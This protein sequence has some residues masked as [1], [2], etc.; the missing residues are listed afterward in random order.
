MLN[1]ADLAL[2]CS[3]LGTTLSPLYEHFSFS[4][5]VALASQNPALLGPWLLDLQPPTPALLP[6]SLSLRQEF[7]GNKPTPHL[8]PAQ[9]SLE[10][11]QPRGGPGTHALPRSSGLCHSHRQSPGQPQHALLVSPD[12]LDP[13]PRPNPGATYLNTAGEAAFP[14]S[15]LGFGA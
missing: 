13:R 4:W 8:R 7:R 5:S 14:G 10:R 15:L 3:C 2:Q 1:K 9:V 6:V 11:H 12:R